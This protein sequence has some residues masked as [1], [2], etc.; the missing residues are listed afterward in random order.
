MLGGKTFTLQKKWN[1]VLREKK[2]ILLEAFVKQSLGKKKTVYFL[3]RH[4]VLSWILNLF[5]M[6]SEK[7]GTGIC[8]CA[9][10][11]SPFV[12]SLWCVIKLKSEY[13]GFGS[14]TWLWKLLI[15]EI[16]KTL[17]SNTLEEQRHFHYLR[18]FTYLLLQL[19]LTW[20]LIL[21]YTGDSTGNYSHFGS[22]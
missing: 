18:N 2:K 13:T 15:Q 16:S 17:C 8:N 20:N 7:L 19:N 3:S 6:L 21:L 11:H 5:N 9:V 4:L 12:W 1:W 10:F 22:S 14:H